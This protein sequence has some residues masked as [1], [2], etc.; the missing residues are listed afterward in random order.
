MANYIKSVTNGEITL[1]ISD[2]GAVKIE[3]NG[4]FL[5]CLPP[6]AFTALVSL[7]RESLGE[8]FD[9]VIAIKEESKKQRDSSK[10]ELQIL[11]EKQKLEAKMQALRDQMNVLGQK[12]G[13]GIKTA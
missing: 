10:L 4:K 12:T 5:A 11:K 1:S 13:Q 9:T 2:K 3:S 7:D 8:A 6:N